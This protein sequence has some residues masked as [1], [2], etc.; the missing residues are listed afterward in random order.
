MSRI[1]YRRLDAFNFFGRLL[2]CIHQTNCLRKYTHAL[3]IQIIQSVFG[4]RV[5]IAHQAKIGFLYH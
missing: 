4:A 2:A 3:K 1:T 5:V